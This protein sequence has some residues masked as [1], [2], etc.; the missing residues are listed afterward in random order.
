MHVKKDEDVWIQT[1]MDQTNQKENKGLVMLNMYEQ[2][3]PQTS[4]F[5]FRRNFVDGQFVKPFMPYHEKRN[6]ML[7]YCHNGWCY[8]LKSGSNYFLTVTYALPQSVQGRE[9][10]IRVFGTDLKL[11]KLE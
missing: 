11:T 10:M 1:L 7:N 5:D 3:Q 4:R 8:K 6:K 9:F 2:G